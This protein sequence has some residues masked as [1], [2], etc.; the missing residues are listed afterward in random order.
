MSVPSDLEI[1]QAA[2]VKPIL[3]IAASIG[4]SEDDLELYGKYKAKVH[5]D[6][7]DKFADR[8]QG[9]IL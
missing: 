5:L 8:L 4:L 9:D 1:A 3:D 6:V 2:T 7:P